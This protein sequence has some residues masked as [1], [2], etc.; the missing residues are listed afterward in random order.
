MSNLTLNRPADA[1]E[2]VVAW[3][4]AIET[5]DRPVLLVLTQQNLPTLDRSRYVGDAREV[6]S[7]ESCGASAPASVLLRELG[8]TTDNVVAKARRLMTCFTR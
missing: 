5:R 6:L 3:K 1:N 7:V 4:V 8:F 2:T